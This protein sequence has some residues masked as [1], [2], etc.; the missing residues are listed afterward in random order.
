MTSALI[1]PH[2][3][4]PIL[5]SV[6]VLDATYGV[7]DAMGGFQMAHIGDAQFFDIDAVADPKAPYPH[8]LPKPEQFAAAVGAMGIGNDDEV[9]VYDQNGIS[10]AASRVWWMF[11]VMGHNKVRV[12]NGGLAAWRMAG[13]ATQS[14]PAADVTPKDFKAKLRSEL[15]RDFE[16]MEEDTDDLVIDARGAARF[17]AMGHTADGDVVPQHI[18]GSINQ[19]FQNLLDAGGALRSADEIA[20]ML[21]PLI[22]PGRALVAT[23]GSGVTACVLA[24]GFHESGFPDMAVY[25]GSWT[26]WSDR[27][28]V[29]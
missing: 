2:E 17:Q 23:C 14:G 4:S 21:L 19:P 9:I 29:R 22:E 18:P 7:P 20:P 24:L 28:G 25:D 8:T 15:F 26:E 3:L 1:T 12:L 10:F 11:R 16:D 13:L 27:N 6:K 5:S